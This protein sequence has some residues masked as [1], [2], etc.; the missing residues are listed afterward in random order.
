LRFPIHADFNYHQIVH[1][2]NSADA[3]LTANFKPIAGT[4]DDFFSAGASLDQIFGG[5]EFV[6]QFAAKAGYDISLPGFGT[7]D[8]FSVGM[9]LTQ[10]RPSPFQGACF[11]RPLRERTLTANGCPD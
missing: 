10:I 6:A 9:D 1:S 5:K 3:G 8:N 2:N 4:V 7:G 11:S